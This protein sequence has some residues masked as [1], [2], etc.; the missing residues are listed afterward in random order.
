MKDLARS[1][2]LF[3]AESLRYCLDA[4]NTDISVFGVKEVNLTK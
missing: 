3:D 2:K 1:N 4:E